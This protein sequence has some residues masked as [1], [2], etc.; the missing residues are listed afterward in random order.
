MYGGSLDSDGDASYGNTTQMVWTEAD[1]NAYTG[2]MASADSNGD[3]FIAED[4]LVGFQ[5]VY[6]GSGSLDSLDSDG[7]G[8]LS[9][10]EFN[11]YTG[12]MASADSNG[13]GSISESELTVFQM[14]YGHDVSFLLM[15]TD[16]DGR[17][18]DY[19]FDMWFFAVECPF[20]SSFRSSPWTINV[21]DCMCNAGYTGPNGKACEACPSGTYK[22]FVG[23]R[24]YTNCSN[25]THSTS[26]CLPCP[27]NTFSLNGSVICAPCP[28]RSQSVPASSSCQCEEGFQRK[29]KEEL[30]QGCLIRLR[31]TADRD[32][33]NVTR[34]MIEILLQSKANSSSSDLME[35]VLRAETSTF[36]SCPQDDISISRAAAPGASSRRGTSEHVQ[37]T[38]VKV[39]L[40]DD[41]V[42]ELAR[43]AETRELLHEFLALDLRFKFQVMDITITCGQGF[44]P[45]RAT[46]GVAGVRRSSHVSSACLPCSRGFYKSALDN[47]SCLPCP[48]QSKTPRTGA[49]NASMCECEEGWVNALANASEAGLAST[50]GG[51]ECV[52][53][54]QFVSVEQ[55]KLAAQTI[56]TA[57]GAIVGTNVAIAVT[58]AVVSSVS[59]AA[60]AGSGGAV[61]VGG[62]AG[63]A[64]S[65]GGTV[66]LLTQVQFLNQAGRIG[67]SNASRAMSA[68][69]SGFGWA[70]FK[71]LVNLGRSGQ[72][73]R[74]GGK[75]GPGKAD[76]LN[77]DGKLSDR[78]LGEWKKKNEVSTTIE[79]I[80]GGGNMSQASATC[81][82]DD[83]APPLETVMACVSALACI[84]I[85]RNALVLTLSFCFQR[86]QPPTLLFPAW[87]APVALVQYLSL[88]DSALQA[89]ALLCPSGV[90]LGVLILLC[91]PLAFLFIAFRRVPTHIRQGKMA[92]EKGPAIPSFSELR[93]TV[94]EGKGLVAKAVIVHAWW[95]SNQERGGWEDT[96]EFAY[97]GFLVS[98]FQGAA[99]MFAFW[100]LLKR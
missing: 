89:T 90:T 96:K 15:D 77:G 66:T 76:D 19:E 56:S 63:G 13:D 20:G 72:Q 94:A 74:R 87:E 70:N 24:A 18:N 81:S 92:F 10:A 83:V 98:D 68:F 84:F 53:I 30:R 62:S 51:P 95:T 5:T 34:F 22:P 71:G 41:I 28:R 49:R 38:L 99:W 3:G 9:E 31:T 91:G 29:K 40:E 16:G 88:S 8:V 33:S 44:S 57:L 2:S 25:T 73:G 67:G 39:I 93:S 27:Q 58:T 97:W 35:D 4:E 54:R 78:E 64:G 6:G 86:D 60:A 43:L 69:S 82:F 26:A 1:F 52:S 11:V 85:A 48:S 37:H 23:S 100:L 61:T 32:S 65:S 47:S 55:A 45:D 21:S 75:E 80:D 50:D 7:D 59:S 17:I 12:S 14:S 46:G 42:V 79:A 36:F